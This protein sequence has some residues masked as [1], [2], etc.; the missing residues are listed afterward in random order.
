M[1]NASQGHIIFQAQDFIL[2]DELRWGKGKRRAYDQLRAQSVSRVGLWIDDGVDEPTLTEWY[3]APAP[4]DPHKGALLWRMDC[5]VREFGNKWYVTVLYFGLDYRCGIDSPPPAGPAHAK[6]VS[7][8]IFKFRDVNGCFVIEPAFPPHPG[9]SPRHHRL[10]EAPEVAM[11]C[12]LF[13]SYRRDDADHVE[14]L[15]ERLAGIEG[16]VFLDDVDLLSN[17]VWDHSTRRSQIASHVVVICCYRS[18]ATFDYLISSIADRKHYNVFMRSAVKPSAAARECSFDELHLEIAA[19]MHRVELSDDK[20]GCDA[21]D[22]SGS[23]FR[24]NYR[25]INDSHFQRDMTETCRV[26]HRHR[27]KRRMDSSRRRSISSIDASILALPGE[28]Q[29]VTTTT[30]VLRELASKSK[31]VSPKGGAGKSAIVVHVAGAALRSCESLR[32]CYLSQ[33]PSRQDDGD[34]EL[35]VASLRGSG[36]SFGRFESDAGALQ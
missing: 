24:F 5:A 34:R 10:D 12:N 16:S 33:M 8:D 28:Q 14:G 36:G 25:Q 9:G 19:S 18:T 7:R 31:D 22:R 6:V 15:R 2:R 32:N 17:E 3:S 35:R 29:I 30:M 23:R 27:A 26:E 1:G 21:F 4:S 13:L 11:L 20:P